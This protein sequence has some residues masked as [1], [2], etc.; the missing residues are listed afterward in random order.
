MTFPQ[1]E[2]SS[3]HPLNQI[4]EAEKQRE[5]QQRD[6]VITPTTNNNKANK[7]IS[8]YHFLSA[9]LTLYSTVTCALHYAL[10]SLSRLEVMT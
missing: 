10:I 1:A 3:G 2:G 7:M 9:V 6:S 8:I 5:S 4:E